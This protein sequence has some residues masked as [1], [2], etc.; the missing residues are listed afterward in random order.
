[1]DDVITSMQYNSATIELQIAACRFIA[2]YAAK[3]GWLFQLCHTLHK[4]SH[5]PVAA[6]ARAA[7]YRTD[8]IEQIVQTLRLC[9]ERADLVE[10][11]VGAVHASSIQNSATYSRLCHLIASHMLFYVEEN[12]SKFIEMM[13]VSTVIDLAFV[14]S[15]K[16]LL[17]ENVLKLLDQCTV[18]SGI[19]NLLHSS[20]IFSKCK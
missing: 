15:S 12:Q 13:G 3:S 7:V 16:I 19:L 9:G 18:A 11:A 6:N 5:F 8:G 10:T 14:F 20:C 1:M 4:R 2:T 17:Q